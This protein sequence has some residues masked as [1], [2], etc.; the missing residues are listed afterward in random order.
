MFLAV[1]D[2][3][4]YIVVQSVVIAQ[5]LVAQI[6]KI[7]EDGVRTVDLVTDLFQQNTFAAAPDTSQ[8]LDDVLANERTNFC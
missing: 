4:A 1:A 2:F 6:L 7:Q 5:M 8:D 3:L